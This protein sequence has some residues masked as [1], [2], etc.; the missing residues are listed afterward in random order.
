[1]EDGVVPMRG[2][3]CRLCDQTG[4]VGR[5]GVFEVLVVTPA[6]RR[7]LLERPTESEVFDVAREQGFTT[8]RE[9]GLSLARQGITTYEE[10]LRVTAG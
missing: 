3:G 4:F 8:M 7:R 1:V 9:H 6:L 2:R 10:V 5:R